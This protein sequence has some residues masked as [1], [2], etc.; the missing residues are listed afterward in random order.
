MC[1]CLSWVCDST[2]NMQSR[3]EDTQCKD[4]HGTADAKGPVQVQEPPH[5]E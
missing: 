4:C 2:D 1:S 3:A 5:L